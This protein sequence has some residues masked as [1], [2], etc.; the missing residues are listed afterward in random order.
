MDQFDQDDTYTQDNLFVEIKTEVDEFLHILSTYPA[1]SEFK[2]QVEVMFQALE[3][4]YSGVNFTQ[5]QLLDTKTKLKTNVKNKTEITK[6]IEDDLERYESLKKE[7]ENFNLKIDQVKFEEEEKE[8]KLADQKIEISRLNQKKDQE[9]LANFSPKDV[10]K[11]QEL[12]S[13]NEA[14]EMDLKE[15]LDKNQQCFEKT[16]NI[17]I[18]KKEIEKLGQQK[19]KLLTEL[20]KQKLD[21]EKQILEA[22]ESKEKNDKE[23]KLLKEKGQTIDKQLEDLNN[24]TEELQNESKNLTLKKDEFEKKQREIT[25]EI[26]LLQNKHI[27][28]ANKEKNENIEK[29]KKQ[30]KT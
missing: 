16:N 7:V 28:S 4:Q 1:L 14:L 13:K 19:R 8:K 29:K 26:V 6:S 24:K 3:S 10:A 18:E 25:G 23:F 9:A 5:R 30:K 11:K 22:K 12:I 20:E 15:A 2:A 21:Y 17:T 27:P